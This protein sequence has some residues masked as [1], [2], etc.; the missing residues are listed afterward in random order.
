MN[1]H[2]C[3][4]CGN[5]LPQRGYHCGTCGRQ[6][7]CKNANC[8]ELREA[9]E[10]FCLFCGTAIP[11]EEKLTSASSST[12]KTTS[13]IHWKQQK[14]KYEEASLDAE[15]T[16]VAFSYLGGPLGSL[17]T[18]SL[19]TGK[20]ANGRPPRNGNVASTNQLAL[21]GTTPESHTEKSEDVVDTTFTDNKQP[22]LSMNTD[23]A[24]LKRIFRLEGEEGHQFRLV[25][26]RLKAAGQLDYTKRLTYLVLY[27]NELENRPL[28]PRIDLNAI[29][30]KN[31]VRDANYSGWFTNSGDLDRDGDTVGLTAS[32]REMAIKTLNE[33]L[34]EG[35]TG[36]MRETA[37]RSRNDKKQSSSDDHIEQT[38]K[39]PT[40]K[41]NTTSKTV[42]E[43]VSKW[44][45]TQAITNGHTLIKERSSLD[46]GLF[47]L[48]A[49]R[50][51]MGDAGKEVA[52]EKLHQFLWEAFEV[53]VDGRTLETALKSKA[54]AGKVQNVRGVTFQILPPGMDHAEKIA[55]S[56]LA[57][58]ATPSLDKPETA[59]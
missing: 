26:T 24:K 58:S 31:A 30:D 40:R 44:K 8:L 27:A 6:C 59:T 1:E 12:S 38:N 11:D 25:E 18:N 56:S 37:S 19:D 16:D 29:L 9:D 41:G 39:A 42:V 28:T 2:S 21:P 3:F 15:L 4:S 14:S 54:A 5:L 53:N 20:L 55:K 35:P 48:W 34:T 46:K 52:R 47:G 7:R 32:G 43:W 22:T 10:K 51:A 13:Q 50:C 45:S 23:Q 57:G 33:V 17:I 36:W 49:I